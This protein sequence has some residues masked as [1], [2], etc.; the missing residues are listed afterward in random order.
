MSIIVNKTPSSPLLLTRWR[1]DK[2]DV[3]INDNT[4]TIFIHPKSRDVY[5]I[6]V[7]E[8]PKIEEVAT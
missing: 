3:V 8:V 6:T 2:L 1:V 4:K 7:Q 5:S